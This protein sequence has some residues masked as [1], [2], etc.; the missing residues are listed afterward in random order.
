MFASVNWPDVAIRA[1]KT[2]GQAFAA[3]VVVG[4]ANVT[5][6]ASALTLAETAAWAGVVAGASF[7]NNAAVIPVW[8]AAFGWVGSK[9]GQE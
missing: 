2:F 9:F 5:D 4:F 8:N 1:A 3:I 6:V 7:L